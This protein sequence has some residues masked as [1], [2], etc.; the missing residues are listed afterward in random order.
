MA[1]K[2]K[3]LTTEE[4]WRELS[5]DIKE[6]STPEGFKN[7]LKLYNE[8]T[9]GREVYDEYPIIQK[10]VCEKI[11]LKQCKTRE[12]K[13]A[14]KAQMKQYKKDSKTSSFPVYNY[15]R[16]LNS[17]AFFSVALQNGN[18]NLSEMDNVIETM[19]N[20][21]SL[22]LGNSAYANGEYQKIAIAIAKADGKTVDE[23]TKSKKSA[24]KA[25]SNYA[26]ELEYI[27]KE[28]DA[29]DKPKAKTADNSKS[30]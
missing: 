14:L 29:L 16:H 26:D 12:G 4:K 30:L 24:P 18:Y 19:R 2:P 17:L 20:N 15:S 10:K 6:I 23:T 25:K 3:E 11:L 28:L 7:F 1:R 13:K 21:G 27:Q 5:T 9:S 22:G 8:L